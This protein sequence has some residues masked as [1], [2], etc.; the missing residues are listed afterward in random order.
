MHQPPAPNARE[1]L[2]PLLACLP[3]AFISPQAPPALLPLLAPILRQR[4]QFISPSSPT[5]R[6]GWLPLLSWDQRRAERLPAAVERMELEPH[7]VSGEV[8]LDDVRPAKYRRLDSETLQARLEV[9]QFDLLPVYVWCEN[10]EHGGTGPGWKLT[11]LKTMEDLEDEAQWFDTQTLA[12]DAANTRSFSVPQANGS[13]QSQTL[14]QDD[15]DD[16]DYWGAYDR[17]PGRTPA[18]KASPA[19]PALSFIQTTQRNQPQSEEDEY[20]A[21]Y[22]AEVQPAMDSHD[23]DEDHEH[24]G[25]STLSGDAL[26]RAQARQSQLG[27]PNNNPPPPMFPADPKPHDS[28]MASRTDLSMP[29]P[30]SPTSSHGS[31]DKLEEQAA[32]MSTADASSDRAQLGVKQHI[33]TDI[34]SLFRLARSA[35]MER[36]EFE[37]I[38]RTELDCLAIM[39]QDD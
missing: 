26:V 5:G 4:L 12:N 9:E 10:D 2:P 19:P 32:A 39:E 25:E 24:I 29:R 21:R 15:D 36:A 17:S 6:D 7:P 31:V 33:S 38:V 27:L 11:E 34:K 1:L 20:Y 3:T 16:D 30:I 35:G 8:E 23:P 28:V 37:R 14:D 22:G 18:Q 13:S